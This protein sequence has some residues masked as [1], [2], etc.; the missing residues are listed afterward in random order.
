[1]SKSEFKY[2]GKDLEV[3]SGVVNYNEWILDNFNPYIGKKVLEVGAGRG[4]LTKFILDY[5]KPN[6]LTSIEPSKEM[7]PILEQLTIQYE[8]LE[9]KNGF[10]DIIDGEKFDSIIYINV[11]EHVQDDQAELELAFNYLNP[12]GHILMFSPA[13]PLLMSDFDRSIGHFRR[14]TMTDK[15]TKTKKAGFDIISNKY[16]DFPGMFLWF[17]IYRILK[18]NPQANSAS[19]YDNIVIPILRIFDPAK[20]LFCGKNVMVVGKKN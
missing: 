4:S 9:T 6:H 20:Y 10:L 14:Y 5:L 16:M 13:L 12:N 1:M 15:I 3:M 7:Y 2:E 8:N 11:M 19:A 17:I 18:L